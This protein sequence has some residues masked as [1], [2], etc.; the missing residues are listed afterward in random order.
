MTEQL[1]ECAFEI[2]N[3]EPDMVH[4]VSHLIMC[5]ERRIEWVLVE[6]P[7]LPCFLIFQ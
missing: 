4:S 6:F 1:F 5:A 7:L 2:I 3:C